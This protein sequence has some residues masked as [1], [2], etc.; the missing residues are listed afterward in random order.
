MPVPIE[1]SQPTFRRGSSGRRV[2]SAPRV[3]VKECRRNPSIAMRAEPTEKVV[4]RGKG[5]VRT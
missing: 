4:E 2:G 3:A 5:K 1:R